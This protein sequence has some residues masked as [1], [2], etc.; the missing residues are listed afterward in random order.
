LSLFSSSL[1]HFFKSHPIY[2]ISNDRLCISPL[3]VPKLWIADPLVI[4][5]SL[6]RVWEGE[7]GQ[8]MRIK[9]ERMKYKQKKK[10]K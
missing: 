2:D 3:A 9:R 7:E 8:K 4:C 1:L 10:G 5:R 6:Q